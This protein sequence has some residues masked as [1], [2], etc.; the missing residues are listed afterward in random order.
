VGNSARFGVIFLMGLAIAVARLVEVEL[1]PPKLSVAAAE[2]KASPLASPAA[3]SA[4]EAKRVAPA[5][6][7][8]APTKGREYTVRS[9]DTLQKISKRAYGTTR[10]WQ[11]ILAANK[12][13]I[14]NLKRMRAGTR[15]VLPKV[16]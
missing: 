14:P 15:L 8:P 10:H 11:A 7:R 6:P 2:A 12:K 16:K 9:G 1:R 5:K 4:P 3:K 13:A